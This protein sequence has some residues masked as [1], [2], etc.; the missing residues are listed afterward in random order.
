MAISC[1]FC[2]TSTEGDPP[3]TW[4]L[5]MERGQ[6][7]RYCEGCTRNNVRGMEGKL[8]PEHW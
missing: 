3:V 8:D 4:S 7:K 5:S 2:G 1:D 6:V